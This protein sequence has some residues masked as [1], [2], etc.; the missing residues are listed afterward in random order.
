[1]SEQPLRIG[2]GYDLHRLV[3]GRKLFLGGVE[4]PFAKGLLGHSDGDV[5]LHAV[6]DGLLGACGC[7]DIGIHFP[8]T[9]KEFEGIASTELLRRTYQLVKKEKL[10]KI[11][12]IDMVVV[13]DN[14]KIDGYRDKII[15]SISEILQT[16]PEKINIKAK[17][18]EKTA[19]DTIESYVAVL[20]E[21]K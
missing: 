18:T 14:P 15:S 3:K 7:G 13:C 9:Q 12:N 20:I 21:V 1:M 19:E 4:I 8:D 5:L 11:V 16:S 10:H 2:I 6:C 17:T